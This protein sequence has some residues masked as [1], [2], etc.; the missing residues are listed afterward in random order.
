MSSAP[1]VGEDEGSR[2]RPDLAVLPA[3][4]WVVV[5][6]GLLGVATGIIV[7]AWPR[8]SLVT[9]AW[10][11]GIFLLIDGV[12]ELA[13]ALS[14]RSE[15]RGIL[16][17]LGA[18]S[19]IAGLVLIRHPVHGVI[20]IALLLGI[21]FVVI[22]VLRVGEALGRAE[23]HRGW[24]VIVGVLE[25]IAGVIIVSDAR[26][27]VTALAIIVGVGFILRGGLTAAAGWLLRAAGRVS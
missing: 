15:N 8:I 7:L 20:A 14:H 12:L 21:W 6:L 24:D 22:G 27:G 4:W 2:Q 16:A 1:R 11:T 5:V 17:L 19:L 9:L 18:L 25:V 26:I 23:R 3:R 13:A 10:I